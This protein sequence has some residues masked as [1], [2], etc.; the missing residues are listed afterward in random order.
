VC[1]KV[2]W[3]ICDNGG[4]LE[5]KVVNC[6]H[7]IFVIF[8]SSTL[9]NNV[10]MTVVIPNLIHKMVVDNV[11]EQIAFL[12]VAILNPRWRPSSIQDGG[13]L[14]IQDGGSHMIFFIIPSA[15]L[16]LIMGI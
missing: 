9:S 3:G 8:P 1:I 16:T 13:H 14:Q 6:F 12:V 2:L 11:I 4:H 15:S 7:M 10:D 5:I